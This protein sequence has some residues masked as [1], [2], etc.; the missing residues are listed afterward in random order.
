MTRLEVWLRRHDCERPADPMWGRGF[1]GYQVFAVDQL[2]QS[3]RSDTGHVS[4]GVAVLLSGPHDACAGAWFDAFEPAAAWARSGRQSQMYTVVEIRRASVVNLWDDGTS[5][6]H[7]ALLLG[8]HLERDDV[9]CLRWA[10]GLDP[11]SSH[12]LGR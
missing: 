6:D 1:P 11:R 9:A 2:P 12:W 5:R 8:P 4:T 10:K 7:R 3:F